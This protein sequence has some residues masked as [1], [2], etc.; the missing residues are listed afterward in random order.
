MFYNKY[1]FLEECFN[2][3]NMKLTQKQKEAEHEEQT[4]T[5]TPRFSQPVGRPLNR[6][7][8]FPTSARGRS[9]LF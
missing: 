4:Q 9:I 8:S 6:L 5:T 1:K 2:N 7:V 3:V